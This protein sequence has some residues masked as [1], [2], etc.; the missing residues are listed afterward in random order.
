MKINI[1][2]VRDFINPLLSKKSIDKSKFEKF[3]ENLI[4]YKREIESQ[5]ASKQTEPNIV[6]NAL[7]P[8]IDSLGYQS[9]AY[10]QTGQSGIDLAILKDYKPAAIFE[11]KAFQSNGMIT[12][13]NLNKK[14]FHE[15]ILYFM[16]ERDRGNVSIFHIVITDFFNWFIFDAKDFD[17]HFWKNKTIKKLYDNNK[18]PSILGDGTADFYSALERALPELMENLIDEV[19]IDCAYF[20]LKETQ[21]EKNLIAIYK[22]LSS[23]CLLKEFNPND[24]NSLNREFYNEL[25]YIL[26]LEEEKSGGK[27]LI[28]RAI[29]PQNGTFY[30]LTKSELSFSE[31]E[32]EFDTIIQIIIIWLNRIL[33][34][35]LLESQIV[36]WNGNKQ[37]LKFLNTSKIENFDRL[38]MLFFKILAVKIDERQN[39]EFDY[40]PYLNSSLFERHALEEKYLRISEL[41]NDAQIAY[42]K[43]TALK[44]ANKKR[45][46]GYTNLL[47]YLF[48]FLDAY[49]FGTDSG[50]EISN[51]NKSLIN[52][53]VLGLIFEKLNGY[54]DGSFY[55]P[56]FITMYMA[57][58]SII[59]SVLQKFNDAKG[60]NCQK[61]LD[62]HNKIDDIQEANTIIDTLT[63]CDPAVGS[64]HFLVSALN[65]ILFIKSELG[66]LVDDEGKR[67]RDYRLS[68]ENDELI[69]KDDEGE[70]FDYQRDSKA[71]A[72]I[73]KTLFKEKQRI[74]EHSLF[75]V[76]INPNSVNIC[77]LRLWVELLKNAYYREDG[78]LDTL[79]NIDINIKCGN[80]LISRFGLNDELK[81]KNIAVEIENYKQRVSDYKENL[82]TKKDVMHSIGELKNKFRLTLQAESKVI[83]DRNQALKNYVLHYRH[84]KLSDDLSLTAIKNN[85]GLNASLFEEKVNPKQQ[86]KMLDELL[87]HQSKINEIEKGKIYDNAFEW[88]FEFPEVLD[89][90]GDF[91]GFDVVIGNPPYVFAREHFTAQEKSFFVSQYKLSAYQL[92]LY[93]LFLERSNQ[94]LKKNGQFSFIVPNNWLTINSAKGVREFILNHS[95]IGIVNFTAKVFDE[96]NVDT[97]ILTYNKSDQ[98]PIVHLYESSGIEGMNL[99]KTTEASFFQNKTD[100]IINIE[101]F[102]NAGVYEIVDKIEANAFL[103]K[104]VA[105]VKA[106]LKAYETGKGKPPQTEEMKKNRIYHSVEQHAE[107]YLPYLDGKDVSRYALGW[108]G[109]FLKYG[110]NL[111]APRTFDLFSTSR[112]LVRQIPSRPPYCIHACFTDEIILNDLNSMNI[113]NIKELPLFILGVLNS[114]L[115]SFW[116]IHKFGK[117]SRGI[118]PQFKINEL[119]QFPIIKNVD[120]K[121]QNIF[122]VLVNYILYLKQQDFY[123]SDDLK[124]AKDRLMVAFFERVIDAIVYELYFPDELHKEDKF[125]ISIL[126]NENLL[127]IDSMN[128]KTEEIRMLFD[129]LNDKNHVIKK[130][131]FFLDSVEVVRIIEGKENANNK[132]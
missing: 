119:E 61:L 90:N 8:F 83:Q 13:D 106:G 7:K 38:N 26:G 129:T 20:N 70:I 102:K 53:S 93:I 42:H 55:T 27:K 22:L 113:I 32:N 112:I 5:H 44:D 3:S 28:G 31:N 36:R 114:R 43:S 23:D 130:N 77:R 84:D 69:I 19:G 87:K 58:E 128:D 109:E 123:K 99:I 72:R 122:S 63:I 18:N 73:Q 65:E 117:L 75:G 98:N 105:D 91:V 94:I 57:R 54:K 62:L 17:I 4:N 39:H 68:V 41:A 124:F 37:E 126:E 79:P 10:S 6:T 121:I 111:A 11:T 120:G 35:K 21:S 49:D 115:M 67:I 118:F 9:V 2:K 125:F 30:E 89:P 86:K 15:A 127:S 59:K 85:Y 110:D 88:R 74:I 16:R 80:S 132:N 131:L 25:L 24:A 66:I 45:K 95:D 81:I 12:R 92:N 64:G 40:V 96:A 46:V 33:F 97:A 34:L 48:E 82:G 101:A 52:P 100:V 50:E 71:K 1:K 14:A 104:E 108:S 51:E 107:N 78:T 116:F 56:S 103:L 29:N 60:W 76:D 47:S